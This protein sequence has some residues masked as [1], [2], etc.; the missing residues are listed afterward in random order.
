MMKINLISI[1]KLDDECYNCEFGSYQCKLRL[2]SQIVAISH[3]DS[4]L[5][6][7][8]FDIAKGLERRWLPIKAADGRCRDKVEPTAMIANFNQLDQDPLVQKQLG[9]S[10]KK[11]DDYHEPPIVR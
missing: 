7:C 2:G 9:S 11:L 6:R 3:K 1:G 10:R 4:T 8:R 5:Y